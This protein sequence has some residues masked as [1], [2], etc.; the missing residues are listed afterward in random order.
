MKFACFSTGSRGNC[1]W[2]K[3]R[4]GEFLIDCGLPRK[5][6]EK[7]LFHVGSAPENLA[8]IIV[9]HEHGD[10][11]S[12]VDG[13][14]DRYKIPV[15]SGLRDAGIPGEDIPIPHDA[16]NNAFFFEE[17]LLYCLDAGSITEEIIR[18]V[19]SAGAVII[20]CNHDKQMVMFCDYPPGVKRRILGP[21]GHLS[22]DQVANILRNAD[23]LPKILVAAH[24]SGHTNT[25]ELA[26]STLEE[27]LYM[28]SAAAQTEIVLSLQDQPTKVMEI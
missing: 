22:N 10:H 14:A 21:T 23:A 19:S 11:C 7:A 26:H 9:S 28:L 4:Q 13:I 27:Q 12:G 16:D 5:V 3:C 15:F 1:T 18:A 8:G 20:D 2:V 25:P 17:G 6:V 24:L